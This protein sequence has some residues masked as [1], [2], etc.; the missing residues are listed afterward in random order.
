MMVHCCSTRP[1]TY[2]DDSL[3]IEAGSLS[4]SHNSQ[5][6]LLTGTTLGSVNT[7]WA[8]NNF[9]ESISYS[10]NYSTTALYDVNYTRDQLGRI[11]EKVETIDG[12]T[13]TYTYAYDEV[14]RLVE[15]LEDGASFEQYAY[16][17]NG[18]RT[19]ATV[20][21]GAA[22]GSYD[23]QD[24]LLSYG[25]TNYTYNAH[26]DLTS[27]T[28]GGQTTSY[29]Y[30]VQGNLIGVT[31]PNGTEIGYLI[32]GQNRRI[33]K[34]VNDTLVQGWLYEDGLNPIAELDGTGTIV[35]RFVYASRINVPDYMI[36]GDTTYRII[37]D[38]LGSPR[39]VINTAS[40]DIVQQMNHD[41]FGNVLQ[42]SNPGF[43]PFGFAGGLYDPD[44]GLVRFGARD[45][46]AEVGRWTAKD[47]ILFAGGDM[48][49]YGYTNS[50]PVNY[51][52]VQGSAAIAGS[53]ALLGSSAATIVRP[54][55]PLTIPRPAPTN[56]VDIVP[57]ISPRSPD[58]RLQDEYKNRPDD[59]LEDEYENRPDD[60]LQD[61]YKNRPDDWL[62]DEYEKHNL[63]GGRGRSKEPCL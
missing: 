15:V 56:H 54:T 42:D 61:E 28:N 60:R 1:G 26:G 19:N 35:S 47:P 5:N 4:L 57:P 46:D 10:A 30:D 55:P 39:L 53:S 9:A 58:D 23:D 33:G 24:R 14:G 8:Y 25:G 48:N 40:G 37:S 63:P 36:Q 11:T 22:S 59:W 3:L 52:D 62:E 29:D 45:Y 32:D 49:L 17:A 16:D 21:G 38:H 31:L 6:G 51:I 34:T 44:T 20:R 12:T 43:Q 27:K 41:A 18:N 2:D 50:D 7:T 13:T